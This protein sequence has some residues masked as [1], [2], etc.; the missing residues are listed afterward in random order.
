MINIL[1]FFTKDRYKWVEMSL[2]VEV[3]G[4]NFEMEDRR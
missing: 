4:G 2:G 1:L 3:Y